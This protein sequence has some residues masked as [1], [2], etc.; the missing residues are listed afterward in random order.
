MLALDTVANLRSNHGFQFKITYSPNGSNSE[1]VTLYGADDQE[2]V[3]KMREMGI[4]E[5]SVG[6]TN[7]ED[8]YLA[9]TGG[10]DGFD[11]RAG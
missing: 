11:D 8:V 10:M 4:Q 6:S 9:I 1:A 3:A 2:L 5:F 7:L